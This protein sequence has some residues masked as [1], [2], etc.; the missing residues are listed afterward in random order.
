MKRLLIILL[1][2]W[3]LPF[4]SM[5][6]QPGTIAPDVQ[7]VLETAAPGDEIAV[8][9]TLTDRVNPAAFKDLNKS[10]RR[11]KLVSALKNKARQTQGQLIAFLQKNG[12]RQLKSFWIFNGLAIKAKADVIHALAERSEVDSIRLDDTLKA[13]RVNTAASAPP[14]WNLDAVRV[15]ELWDM[16]Y[17][18]IGTVIAS[19]DTGV[20]YLH[21]DLNISWRGGGN[22]WFDPNGEHATP[23]DVDGHGT[24]T[25]G[26]M[27]GSDA[28]GSTIGMAP[29][30][31]W[32]AVKI[33]NDAGVAPYSSIH[34]GYQ[35]LLDPDNNAQTDDAPDIVNNSWGLRTGVN[36]CITE[37]QA[38]I[39][40]LKAAG[41]GVVFS[42]G[43]E[44]PNPETS[45]SP[46]NYPQSFATG[47][48]DSDFNVASLS[49][50]GPSTC[51][52]DIFPELVAPGIGIR[53]SDLTL[54]GVFPD[55][56]KTVSGTSFAAPHVSSALALLISA[57]P[58]KSIAELE[59]A[60]KDSAY[61]LGQYDPD[62]D[63]GYGMLDIAAAY[64]LLQNPT[65]CTDA[66]ADGFYAEANCG[67]VV[68]CQDLDATIN[69][70]ACDIKRDGID[71]NCD[72]VDR[73]RGKT[74][75]DQTSDGGGS[76]TGGS[77]G[78]GNTC[79]D[80]LDNDGDGQTDC[81]DSD[82]AKNK[83]CR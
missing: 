15:P 13:P 61:D 65:G 16:G 78:K 75:S 33:F 14:E 5:A 49:S 32:I 81:S 3:L 80:G 52:G 48:V 60:M 54:G 11:G 59:Q 24:Q 38:D 69:P 77:E 47:A 42:A 37:F 50:R 76:T 74:C 41:I 28:G 66:D 10:E 82:C 43:N 27:V 56:Y 8:I 39:E 51:D 63:Y 72:G 79:S 30:A 1:F 35:W 53:S 7:G 36:E 71:Q 29:G 68:D 21:P 31:L 19:M 26:I 73:T 46:A 25:M 18:G 62:N 45:V 40:V 23:Y 20:D 4:S 70:A 9:V 58:D 12:A 2:C 55:S 6:V 44:G 57:F 67:T 64:A 83:S 17:T 34:Q 22:S